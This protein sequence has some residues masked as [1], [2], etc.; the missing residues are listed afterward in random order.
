MTTVTVS[1]MPVDPAVSGDF[2]LSTN[3]ILTI[4]ADQTD[5]TGTVTV[6]AVNNTVDAPNKTVTVSATAD[7]TQGVT[8]PAALTLAITDDDAAPVLTLAVGPS[9]IMEAGGSSTVTV[10]ITNGV[11][12]AEDQEIALSFA[13]TATK[14]TDYTVALESLTFT[15]KQSSVATTVTAVQDR[16]DDDAETILITASHGGGT[17][18]AEQ[19][20]TIIDDDPTTC[21]GG[22]A[23]TYP[24]SNVDLMSFLALA[25]I[26][27]GE[28]NDIW[29]WTDSSTGKEY[30]IMGRTTGTSFVDISDPVNP[31]YLGNLP[32]HSSDSE[33][34]DVK[35]YADH[36]FI[37]TEANNSG[38]QVFDLTQLRMV[39][40]PPATF[41][42]TAHYSGFS[43]AHNLAINED[44][45]FAYAVGTNTCSGGL[46]MIDI[47]TPTSPTSAGCFSAD[48]HTHD[49]Q[50]VN[51]DGPDLDHQGK[52]ICFNSNV[53]TLTIVDVTN[54]AAPVQL[55]RTGYS[56]SRYAHQGW[57]TEDHAYFLLDDESDETDNPDVTNTRTYM[58]DVSDLDA[59]AVIGFHDSTT[60]ATDHNQYVKGKYTYQSNYRAGLRILDITDIANGNLS[61]EA[62][63]DI[64]P[65]S[66]STSF[67]GA[68]SNYPFFDSGIVIVSGIEQ[69]L[70]I[71]RP[72]LVDG[73]NPALASA[74]VNGAALT[75]TYGEA[76]DES[77][78]PA[79]DAFTV[80][81]AGSGRTVTHVS[82]IGKVVTLT[83]ASA[84][85][86][87]ETVTVSYSPGTNPIRD[88]AGNG[89]G[90]LSNDPVRNDAPDTTPPTVS[91]IEITSK[92]GTDRTYA[93]GD[94]IEVTVTFSETVEV[95]GTPRL[96]IELGSGRRTANY[97]GGSGTAALV[98]AYEVAEGESDT[99][100]VGVEE[101]SLSGGTIRD[102]ARNNAELDHDGLAADSGHK[103]D[104]VKPK[105]ASTN[106]AVVNGATLTLTY[107]EPLDGSSTP[108]ASAFTV[109]GGGASRTVTDVALSGSAVFLTLDPAVEHGQTGIRVSYRVPT[110]AGESPLQ[111]ALG[112]DADRL[113]NVPV[114]NETTD[115]TSPTVDKLEITSNPGSDRTYAADDEIQVTAT[116]S[117]TV[118]VTGTPQLRL[119][120]GGGTRTATYEG[121]TGTAALVFALRGG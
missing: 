85:A 27:G 99:D 40:S 8:P 32:P 31:I 42:E 65:G 53:D 59:P 109:T 117:E 89:A 30:A 113:S 51:Y 43:T 69:G 64:Y 24:C 14:G 67:D 90:G 3:R 114:T 52:E 48:G 80:T 102:E 116:F 5:S 11:T 103:V 94:E 108:P 58:W 47:Q 33:W 28:A 81:V 61:E 75:L 54:K 106:G 10:R 74:A 2:V 12:F 97:Q 79:T 22:M 84:V 9:A 38:M 93:A 107:D 44:S 104:G 17:I 25:N 29:G 110:G 66:D 115:T 78:T 56:G 121:G 101:D 82:V 21:S 1:A 73:V 16:V 92:S 77:S 118:E 35:V 87:G 98:F 36:A 50:C 72:N 13:G 60:T 4:A 62:F 91:M 39:A 34:R 119:E 55:S 76:L 23:G 70:F 71:L 95:E 7:N 111:D 88:A 83:L 18:G 57:L 63:F 19:T 68:W 26:G 105:L 20:I 41:S 86:H 37:V 112:N 96:T 100:G 46:H 45:G 6:R 120:L 15:A 49:A